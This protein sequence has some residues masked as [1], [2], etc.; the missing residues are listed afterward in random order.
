MSTFDQSEF[1]ELAITKLQQDGIPK[2]HI[3]AVP[4][5]LSQKQ[6]GLGDTIHYSDGKSFLDVAALVSLRAPLGSCRLGNR[7]L[8]FWWNP[9]FYSQLYNGP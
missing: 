2:E 5:D 6:Q 7:W 3:L 1:L 4:L 9:W 8:S